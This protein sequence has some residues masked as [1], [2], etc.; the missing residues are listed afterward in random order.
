MVWRTNREYNWRFCAG[1]ILILIYYL[2]IWEKEWYILPVIFVSILLFGKY[3]CCREAWKAGEQKQKQFR[4][5]LES[6]QFFYQ[7]HQTIEAAFEELSEEYP[8]VRK[9]AV[10][11]KLAGER[12]KEEE[13]V[14][15]IHMRIF[16]L[17]LELYALY[18]REESFLKGIGLIKECL[19]EELL[20][21]Q[22]RKQ[23]FSG[24]FLLLL[25]SLFCIKP[26]ERWAGNNVEE[27][28]PYYAGVQGR[29]TEI[30]CLGVIFLTARVFIWLCF[31]QRYE[32]KQ[33]VGVIIRL[34]EREWI[35]RG[36]KRHIR[37]FRKHYEWL[38]SLIRYV[39]YEGDC[40]RFLLKQ[41][42]RT[43]GCL[44]LFLVLGF[45]IKGS[46]VGFW[47]F[48]IFAGILAWLS[49]YLD[50]LLC[51]YQLEFIREQEILY[52]QTVLLVA[53]NTEDISTEELNSWLIQAADYYQGI[54]L[55]LA[56]RLE[57]V[58]EKEILSLSG[59]KKDIFYHILEGLV[60]GRD[61]GWKSVFS[62]IEGEQIF[63]QKKNYQRRE[64]RLENEGSIGRVLAMT[65]AFF[66]LLV[67]LIFPFVSEGLTQLSYYTQGML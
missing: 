24:V 46:Y 23:L 41:M 10:Y 60:R 18:G 47:V 44:G 22:K 42:G 19:E 51:W 7:T 64:K 16:F 57:F 14:T 27:L 53:R 29:F 43:G 63:L 28:I 66:I 8:V 33:S 6:F 11:R 65:P 30:L 59:G 34:S 25:G 50:L 31:E 21:Y 62:G 39:H 55:S 5:F 61:F 35:Q 32:R 36:L 58:K 26:I 37:F 54:F 52:L 1:S 40:Q 9:L 45:S 3:L 17:L 48:A 12:V 49:P 4:E 56:G 13:R 20:L 38:Y 67:W 2:L 15:D